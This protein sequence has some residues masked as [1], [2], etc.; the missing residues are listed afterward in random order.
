MSSLRPLR[1]AVASLSGCLLPAAAPPAYPPRTLIVFVAS[2]C[3]PCRVE[4]RQIEAI[5]TIAAPIEVRVTPVDRSSGTE[6]MLR[7]ISAARVWRSARALNTFAQ[8]NGS[9][10]FNLM[11]DTTGRP[12]ATYDRALDP[13]A[14]LIMRRRCDGVS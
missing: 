13:A 2:W 9:L 11:T 8:N 12:C 14:V 6:A 5:A 7:D 3:A 4:L 1:L 10:P